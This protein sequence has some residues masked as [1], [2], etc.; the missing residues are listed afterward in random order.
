[1]N[2]KIVLAVV[3]T[4][5]ACGIAFG[6]YTYTQREV[7]VVEQP[8]PGKNEQPG[9]EDPE[10]GLVRVSS[11]KANDAITSPLVI[12][13]EAWGPWFFE[14]SFPVKLLDGN[15]KVLAQVPAQAQG[16]WMT[17]NFV[18]FKAT[19]TF[20][21]PATATGT[22]VFEKDNPSGLPEHADEFRL[23]IR[24][25]S[26]VSQNEC[27]VTGC[28]SQFCSDQEQTTTCE[29]LPVYACYKQATCERQPSGQ[30][31]WTETP[32]LAACLTN[33]R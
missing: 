3:L 9:N 23:P 30:C 11:L 10:P 17:E 2:N 24:F 15:G 6:I 21:A 16:E 1:M 31:G 18:A 28:S 4:L 19:L 33:A 22:L 25:S 32:A 20:A 8:T 14:A 26:V 27:V 29:Y 7:T 5:V 12:E 13:G